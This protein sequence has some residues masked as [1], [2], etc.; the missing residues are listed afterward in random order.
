L[1][2]FDQYVLGPGTKAAEIIAPSHRADVSR[3]AGWISPVVV[4]GGRVA[5]IW[6]IDGG[7]VEVRL[8]DDAPSIPGPALE[9][10][11]ARIEELL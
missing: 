3:T 11:V 6:A 4:A 5:G 2:A 8:F 7:K 1:P 9:A 10:E